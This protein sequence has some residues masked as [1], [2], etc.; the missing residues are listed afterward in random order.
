MKA[1]ILERTTN[2]IKDFTD[3]LKETESYIPTLTSNL[4]SIVVT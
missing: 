4:E 3:L 2:L 1:S